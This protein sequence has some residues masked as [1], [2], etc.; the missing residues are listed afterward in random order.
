MFSYRIAVL[1]D[2]HA[3]LTALDAVLRALD[4][5][6]P[7]DAIL[8]AGD[9][10]YGP[11]QSATVARLR[12]YNV[13]AVRGNGDV[14]LLNFVDGKMPAYMESLD[15]F[16]LIRWSRANTTVETLDYLRQLP[17]QLVFSLPGA[18][19]IRMV[20]GSTQDVNESL[21][22]EKNP[23]ALD[24]EMS[25]IKEPV[26]VFGHTH[27][28]LK[29]IT[30][31]KLALNPGAVSM[32]IGIPMTAYFAILEWSENTAFW[33]AKHCHIPYPPESYKQEF[34]T[35][36]LL[37]VVPLGP[38]LLATSE[39]GKSLGVDF[40][41]YVLTMKKRAGCG[42]L[43]YIPDEIW[44]QAQKTFILERNHGSRDGEL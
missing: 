18:D 16:A 27:Q 23:D 33:Q 40:M 15:Q 22:P 5:F 2:V 43:P 17:E 1:S 12:E 8:V 37:D 31:G 9:L 42:D 34:V 39:T 25:T 19:S 32:A 38:L 3:S 7:L 6:A 14:D 24:R 41:R 29:K 30:N 11:S 44:S 21:S 10:T 13:N 20:H 35:S 26:L 4:A 28:P 36:G